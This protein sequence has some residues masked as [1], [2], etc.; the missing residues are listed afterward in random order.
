MDIATEELSHLEVIGSIV[1][2]LNRGVKGKM[3]EG[4]QQEAEL[5]REINKGGESHTTSLLAGGGTALWNSAGVTLDCTLHRH[6]WR[7]HSRSALQYRGGGTC[8]NHL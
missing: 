7:A 3:A 4:L 6:H 2:L 5:Y 1:T 8:Q